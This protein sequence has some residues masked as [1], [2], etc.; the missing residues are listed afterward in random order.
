M[1]ITLSLTA[2]IVLLTLVFVTGCGIKPRPQSYKGLAPKMKT[3][4]S[5]DGYL[6]D[7][8]VDWIEVTNNKSID[9]SGVS[10][11]MFS[12]RE[13]GSD[14][15]T[16]ENAATAIEPIPRGMTIKQ[17]TTITSDKLRK[18]VMK[19]TIISM[20][21]FQGCLSGSKLVYSAKIGTYNFNAVAYMFL[22]N[23]KAY[24]FSGGSSDKN[25][26]IYEST[27]DQMARSFR[28]K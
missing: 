27:Y 16:E 17:Y 12:R 10:D 25:F 22:A 6:I 8:P 13:G 26:V 4:A 5:G 20:T 28:W 9:A 11:L 24:V 15:P 14:M 19:A 3:I 7:I 2:F 1:R 21:P 18:G 23:Q